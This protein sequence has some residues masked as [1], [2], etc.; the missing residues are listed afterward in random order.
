MTILPLPFIAP[1]ARRSGLLE[2][3]AAVHDE[4]LTSRVITS[5]KECAFH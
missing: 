4:A 2:G 5:A 3:L 1:L